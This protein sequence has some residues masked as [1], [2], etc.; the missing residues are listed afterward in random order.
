MENGADAVYFGLR[1]GLNARARAKNFSPEELP[2]LMDYLH[3]R[4]VKGYVTLNT[5]VFPEEWEQLEAAVRLSVA[6]GVDAVLVQDLGAARL[7]GALCPDWPLHASTQMSLTSAEGIRAAQSLGIRRVV[8]AR[9]L[10]LDEIQQ[11][12][13]ETQVELEVFV[14]GALCVSYS[15]QC[16]ASLAMGG[17]SGN[18]GQ[19]A[20][21]CRLPYQVL[22]RGASSQL[23]DSQVGNLRHGRPARR[24]KLETCPTRYPLSPYDLAAFDL[25]P[26][27]IAAGVDAVKIEGRLKSAEYVAAVTRQYRRAI[28]EALAGRRLGLTP[29]EIEELEVSFSRGF[30]HGWLEGRNLRL[31]PGHA[32]AKRGV[33]VGEV[34]A[35][36]GCRV[37]VE[38]SRPLRRGDGVVFEGDRNQGDEQGGRVWD[39]STAQVP[40][41]PAS[42]AGPNAQAA[43]ASRELVELSMDREAVD[44]DKLRPGQKVWKTDDPQVARRLRKTYTSTKPQRRV[45]LDLVVEATVGRPLRISAAAGSGAACRIESPEALRDA[46]KHPLTLEVLREQFGRLGGTVYELRGLDARIEGRPMAPL[47]VLGRLRRDLVEQLDAA[48]VRVGPRR[49]AP[50]SPL[51]SLRMAART[52]V[53]FRSAKGRNFRGAKG[54]DAHAQWHVLCQ[55]LEQLE[56]VL[57][58]GASSVTA[59]LADLDQHAEAVALARARGVEIMLAPPRIQKPGEMEIVRRLIDCE[60]D[61]ILARNLATAAVCAE[62]AVP[63]VVDFSLNAVNELTV[64]FL[65]DRGAQRVTAAYDLDR[66]Q[67]LALASLVP[68]E[69]L[70][71]I[72]YSHVPM[73]HSEHCLRVGQ[74]SNLPGSSQGQACARIHGKSKTC[75]TWRLRDRRGAE[76]FLGSDACCR[77]TLYHA[78]PRSLFDLVP[79]L[80]AQGV[81]HF[82]IELLEEMPLDRLSVLL[83]ALPSTSS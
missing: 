40:H 41:P 78:E 38:L 82:R 22:K 74:V 48:A 27:L 61:G 24:G 83:R 34:R 55:S 19:C 64:A 52:S 76:H 47:S 75:P 23:A 15:G 5:L 79:E 16:L 73:F 36:R 35:V 12:R 8:L 66:E 65:R 77:N 13:R 67:L 14:H 39:V 58:L 28:D 4:G 29:E 57:A 33:L 3:L 18:R 56:A 54:D 53:A 69:W 26:E 11:V 80:A 1:S 63:Y 44:L 70:E 7:I 45:A 62:R 10:S 31:V 9:E 42:D 49:L 59:E 43:D 71:V 2:E 51:A 20:Q 50:E 81:R 72:V 17:R 60:A 6:A 32:S 68:A 30:S 25:M 46:Q 21:P 37:V